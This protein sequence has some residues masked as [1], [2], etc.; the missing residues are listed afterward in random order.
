MSLFLAVIGATAAALLEVLPYI[1]VGAA[2]PHPVLV[3]GLIW[4][5]AAGIEGALAWAFVGGMVLDALA[6][7]PLGLSAFALLLAV[8]SCGLLS[9]ALLRIRPLVPIIA[10]ALLSGLYS[11][12]QLV[13]L[14]AIRSPIPIAEP[15]QAVVPGVAYDIV[16]AILFGPL[17]VA[18]RD[19]YVEQERLDW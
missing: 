4:V 3:F 16:L 19:R 9:R 17:A 15:L 8:G 14:G 11:M 18:I 12:L 10:V 7:R 13:L 1:A 5:V 2:H 6:G